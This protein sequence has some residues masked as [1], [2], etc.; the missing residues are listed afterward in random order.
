V[1]RAGA[2][3]LLD[4]V[5][6]LSVAGRC[7]GRERP[8]LWPWLVARGS[9]WLQ[10]GPVAAQRPLTGLLLVAPASLRMLLHI[11]PNQGL[12]RAGARWSVQQICVCTQGQ[13]LLR[14][15]GGGVHP[16]SCTRSVGSCEE[17]ADR[18]LL[19]AVGAL[20][21]ACPMCVPVWTVG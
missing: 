15:G 10:L 9:M 17:G 1:Q 6:A 4:F 8:A 12:W 16:G 11:A 20:P 2:T 5:R 3:F 13:R 18:M 7:L 21:T 14:G 19:P